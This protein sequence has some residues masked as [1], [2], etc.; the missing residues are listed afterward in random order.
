MIIGSKGLH[1]FKASFAWLINLNKTVKVKFFRQLKVP[2][3]W[4][5][6]RRKLRNK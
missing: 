3:V 4:N 2:Y 1:A 6:Q 5:R